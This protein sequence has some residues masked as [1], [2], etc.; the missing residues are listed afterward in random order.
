MQDFTRRGLM[1]GVTAGTVTLSGCS[2][3]GKGIRAITR[4]IRSQQ[5]RTDDSDENETPTPGYD[6][7]DVTDDG[8]P[9]DLDTPER[10]TGPLY[11]YDGTLSVGGNNYRGWRLPV[12][13]PP[14]ATESLT[15]EYEVVVRSGPAVDVLVLD[16]EEYEHYRAGDNYLYY[17]SDSELEAIHATATVNL[18]PADYAFVVDNGAT[19]ET[20]LGSDRDD[21]SV[22]VDVS[23]NGPLAWRPDDE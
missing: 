23:L 14:H 17:R 13:S 10:L 18:E 4:G 3:A 2:K 8:V 1:C 5:E 12:D 6:G 21:A 22:S 16:L 15:L 9:D 19:G 20:V 11:Q 7:T